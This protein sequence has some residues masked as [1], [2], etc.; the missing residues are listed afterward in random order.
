LIEG[1]NINLNR[2]KKLKN[3]EFYTQIKDIENEVPYYAEYFKGATVYCNCDDPV[4]SMFYTYFAQRFESL[5]LKKLIVTHYSPGG[6][7]YKLEITGYINWEGKID[8][9]DTV[10]NPIT[11]NGDFRN[12]ECVVLLQEADIV[13]TN[14][15]FSL[16]REYVSQLVQYDKKFLIIGNSNAIVYK[17]VFPLIKDDKVWLGV[18]YPKRFIQPDG[19]IKSFGNICWFTNLRHCKRN[20]ELVLHKRYTPE[21]YLKYDNYDAINVNKVKDIPY[22]YYGCIGVPITFLYKWNPN[23]FDII[24]CS[25]SYGYPKG[26][27]F[28]DRNF[29]PSINGVQIYRRLFIK[30][31]TLRAL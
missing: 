20:E 23:Q 15:P 6:R 5:G 3:D 7:S 4:Y 10:I 31:N 1:L 21:E 13:V 2:A 9:L 16:F 27:H 19:T 8:K 26:Y 25:F 18:T 28:N 29:D 14:P 22:D 30:N 17:N 11:G 24:G 12:P